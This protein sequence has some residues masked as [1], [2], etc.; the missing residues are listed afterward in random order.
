MSREHWGIRL[1][2]IWS[3][4][5]WIRSKAVKILAVFNTLPTLLPF[6]AAILAAIAAWGSLETA[7]LSYRQQVEHTLSQ[8]RPEILPEGWE[9]RDAVQSAVV[10]ISK[11]TNLGKGTAYRIAEEVRISGKNPNVDVTSLTRFIYF[12]PVNASKEINYEF[13]FDWKHGRQFPGYNPGYKQVKDRVI[14]LELT[15][16]S[17]DA[18]EN[19]HEITFRL[20]TQSQVGQLGGTSVVI[21]KPLPDDMSKLLQTIPPI[22]PGSSMPEVAPGLMLTGVWSSY[23]TKDEVRR[24]VAA[25]GHPQSVDNHP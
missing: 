5:R 12:L 2:Q 24:L 16:I 13:I 6:L 7:K 25:H 18:N 22:S 23:E 3:F 15:F 20:H 8:I 9:F 14:D 17:F 10:K 1:H 21:P 19:R 11:L 4:T